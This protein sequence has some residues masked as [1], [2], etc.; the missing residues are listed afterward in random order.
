MPD[1]DELESTLTDRYQTTVPSPVRRALRLK[2]RDKIRYCVTERGQV[3]LTRATQD[4]DSDPVVRKYLQFLAR[5]MEKHPE[6]IKP[7][8]RTLLKHIRELTQGVKVDLDKPLD[9]DDE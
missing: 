4:E 3:I 8:P 2:K 5:D 7:F 9:S 6:N 1:T